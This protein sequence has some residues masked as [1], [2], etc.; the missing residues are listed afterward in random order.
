[1]IAAATAS[2]WR[3]FGILPLT[4]RA[5]HHT[6]QSCLDHCGAHVGADCLALGN[7]LGTA[8]V[9]P[10]MVRAFAQASGPLEEKLLA[11]MLAGQAAGGEQ[12]PL[13]SAA[14]AVLG[15]AGLMD[16]DLRVDLSDDPLG[17]LV[18]L[19][20]DWQPKAAAYR[21]RA[22]D[23]DAAPSS[24]TVERRQPAPD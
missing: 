2:H 24:A 14:L 13:Q 8:D 19:W 20:Q 9:L 6:G 15:E 5:I 4:G 17:A 22:L 21:L 10:E 16:A 12:E 3:Q 23:P 7:F 11:G 18:V 1:M